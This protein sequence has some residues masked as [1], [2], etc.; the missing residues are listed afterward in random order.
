MKEL[1]K[2]ARHCL[3]LVSPPR[4]KCKNA[5]FARHHLFTRKGSSPPHTASHT[6]CSQYQLGARYPFKTPSKE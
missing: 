3:P 2:E 6:R 1:I 4:R 5:R